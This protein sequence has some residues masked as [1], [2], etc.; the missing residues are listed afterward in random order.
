[1]SDTLHERMKLLMM[2]TL[3]EDFQALLEQAYVAGWREAA[4]WADREDLYEDVSS[5]AYEN[6]RTESLLKLLNP[7]SYARVLERLQTKKKNTNEN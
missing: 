1:M 3:E 7:L 5:I 2:N 6:D 4:R